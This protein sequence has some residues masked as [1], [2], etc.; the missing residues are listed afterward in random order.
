MI[1]IIISIALLL[2]VS[3]SVSSL[4]VSIRT[5]EDSKALLTLVLRGKLNV[6]DPFRCR[7]GTSGSSAKN[8]ALFKIKLPKEGCH[9]RT[10]SGSSKNPF[11]NLTFNKKL[12]SPQYKD[13]LVQ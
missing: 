5:H 13:T 11:V 4:S 3:Y 9:R 12:C 6:T 7:A 2:G 8:T 10:F 1:I